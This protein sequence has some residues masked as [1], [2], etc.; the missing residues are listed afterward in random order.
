MSKPSW[1]KLCWQGTQFCSQCLVT[2]LCWMLWALLGVL[3]IVQTYVATSR[4][5][6]VPDFV[7]REMEKTFAEAGLRLE[8]GQA[9][10]DPTGQFLL[11]DV[12]FSF[13]QISEPAVRAE[14]V[15]IRVNPISLL[16]RK[17]EPESIRITGANLL[18]PA[19]FSPSGTAEALVKDLDATVRLGTKNRTLILEHLTARV[20]PLPIDMHG[21]W[22]WPKAD[23]DPPPLDQLLASIAQNYLTGCDWV[24][25]WL[26]RIPPIE[27]PHLS[28]AIAPHPERLADISMSLRASRV[29]LKLPQLGSQPVTITDVS[30]QTEFALAGPPRITTA[31]VTCR[32]LDWAPH[33]A[34]SQFRGELE[35]LVSLPS[36]R[37]EPRIVSASLG[38]ITTADGQIDSIS[39]RAGIATLPQTQT[40]IVATLLGEPLGIQADI[41]LRS[42]AGRVDFNARLESELIAIAGR[43]VGVDLPGIIAWDVPPAVAGTLNLG[44]KGQLLRAELDLTTGPVDARGVALNATSAHVTWADNQLRAE[45]IQLVSGRSRATGLYLMDAS[46][47]DFRFLLEGRL[48]P[49]DINGWFREW[50][51]DF[52][53]KF[54]FSASP[55][56]ASVEISGRWQAKLDTRLFIQA[57]A[58]N[59]AMEGVAFDRIRTRLFVRPG[60]ADV[61]EF[62]AERAIGTVQGSFSRQWRMPNGQRWTA[63]EVHAEGTSDLVPAPAILGDLGTEIIAPFTMDGPLTVRLDGRVSREDFGQPITS[64]FKITGETAARWT[65][66]DFPLHGTKFSARR[67][68]DVLLIDEFEAGAAQGQLTGRIETRGLGDTARVAFDLNLNGAHLGEAITT[69]NQWTSARNGEEAGPETAFQ[70]QI[71]SGIL[72]LAISAEGPADDPYGYRGAGSALVQ[73]DQLGEINLLGILS[74]LLKRTL[75][76]FSTMELNSVNGDFA[77]EGRELKFSSIKATGPRGALNAVGSYYLDNSR[78]DFVTKVRPFEASRGILNAVL[79]PLSNALEVKLGGELSDPEWTFVYGPTNFLRTLTGE[80]NPAADTLPAPLSAPPGPTPAPA[81]DATPRPILPEPIAAPATESAVPPRKED[82]G[83]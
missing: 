42:L 68:D 29:E 79:S 62:I 73:S 8:F 38:A 50:W 82:R 11:R 17:V 20:G 71:S 66:K 74:T 3:A 77:L 43:R 41:D 4:E 60:W 13:A 37:F 23:S 83:K 34:V 64:D 40:Q 69:V 47:L 14:S 24:R 75:L 56:D 70:K 28:L 6:A 49:P 54:D 44:P 65:F 21:E 30:L 59:A 45:N 2:A 46:N 33:G 52:W 16:L 78:M 1:L 18:V 48:D 57:D 58:R 80:S 15:Y 19:L 10:F 31:S 35:A 27:S 67:V 81:S 61:Q 22:I 12:R 7:L 36:R 53:R 9:V 51:P 72:D 55:P 76:S 32:T 25:R 26:P 39:V 63:V 5:L